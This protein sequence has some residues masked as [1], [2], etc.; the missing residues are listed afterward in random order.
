[1][2]IQFVIGTNVENTIDINVAEAPTEEQAKAIEDDICK[3]M[4]E[5]EEVNGD[6]YGFDYYECCYE[7]VQKHIGVADNP[8]V[9]TIYL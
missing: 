4:D 2:R 8:I 3:M 5:H 1:M 9:R 6:F 7:A